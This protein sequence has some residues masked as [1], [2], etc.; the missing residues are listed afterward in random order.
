MLIE[1]GARVY[2]FAP[3]Y[4]NKTRS[5]IKSIG[6]EPVDFSL[7]ASSM[8]FIRGCCDFFSLTVTLRKLSPDVVLSYFLK[9]SVLGTWASKIIGIKSRYV[10]LEGLGYLFSEHLNTTGQF[11]RMFAL[12]MFASALSHATKVIVLNSEDGAILLEKG[13]VNK[14]QIDVIGGIGIDLSYFSAAP[15]VT[16][17]IQ[18]ILISRLLSEKGISDFV[19][20]ALI[21]KSK[22]PTCKFVVLGGLDKGP[23]AIPERVVQKWVQ[24][25]IIEWYNHVEDVRP[26]LAKSSVFV[27]P[28]YY[29]EGVP[30]SSQEALAMA[31][32]I[33]TTD[34]VGCRD[35]VINGVNGFLVPVR[36]TVRL[37]E[38]MKQF[39]IDPNIISVMGAESRKFAEMYFDV[40]DANQRI[41]AAINLK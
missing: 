12:R 39:V 23:I 6:C 28:S 31:R 18:F 29:R 7:D 40:K 41:L 13:F 8:R 25:G 5:K 14:N 1:K 20:A 26:F 21:V 24:D 37:A 38:A 27:L 36:N 35:T 9:P 34:N 17:P 2:A 33:I 32:P 30:R 15:P 22:Y 3:D 11:A 10:I 19:D 16:S 4:D